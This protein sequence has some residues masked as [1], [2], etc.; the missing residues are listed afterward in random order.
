M[1]LETS[2]ID[3]F[4]VVGLEARTTNALESSGEGVIGKLW[5]R[6]MGDSLLELIP[7]RVDDSIIAVYYD[8]ASDKDGAYSFLLGA[9]VSSAEEVPP[10]MISHEVAKGDYALFTGGGESPAETVLRIWQEI[11]SFE[12]AGLAR[13]YRTDFELY[14]ANSDVAVYVGVLAES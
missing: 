8:Y 2:D 4:L 6:L 9:K 11:W 12:S 14:R 3:S 1:N 10:D 7:A 13:A 5:G